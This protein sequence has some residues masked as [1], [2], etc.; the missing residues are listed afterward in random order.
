MNRY[1]VRMMEIQ[2]HLKLLTNKNEKYA[3]FVK[4]ESTSVNGNYGSGI[5]HIEEDDNH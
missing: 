2:Y 4:R 3:H 1:V 5:H